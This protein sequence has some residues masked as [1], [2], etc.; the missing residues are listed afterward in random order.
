MINRLNLL[1]GLVLCLV[2][3][4]KAQSQNTQIIGTASDNNGPFTLKGSVIDADTG[5]R[6]VGANVVVSRTK[7]G[8]IADQYGEYSLGLDKGYHIL[9]ISFIGHKTNS[10]EISN[11]STTALHSS[12]C[13]VAFFIYLQ[14]LKLSLVHVFK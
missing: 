9:E 3:I 8:A 4:M 6:L 5:E 1:L 11:L 10:I 7:K 2:F 12:Q 13:Y 14:S